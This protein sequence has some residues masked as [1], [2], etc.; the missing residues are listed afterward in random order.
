MNPN[1]QLLLQAFGLK[2]S[3]NS[4]GASGPQFAGGNANPLAA[5]LMAGGQL[6]KR[7]D[8]SGRY[9]LPGPQQQL[10]G[11][12]WLRQ[13]GPGRYMGLNAVTPAAP[14]QAE[15]P[16]PKPFMPTLAQSVV[17]KASQ[18]V[19]AGATKPNRK[20]VFSNLKY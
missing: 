2:G 12:D 5:I 16:K 1:L 9:I 3:S 8:L 19:L 14:A 6:P 7:K 15:P 18:A 4:L 20:N 11:L 13:N 17:S 10:S